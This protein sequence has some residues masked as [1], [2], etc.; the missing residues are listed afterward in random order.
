[1]LR[2]SII[3]I[4]ARAVPSVFGFVTG[5]A[6]T[7]LLTP[8]QYG[9]YGLGLATVT[10]LAGV[11][12]DWHALSFMR[13]F[14]AN[15]ANPTFMPTVTQSFLMLCALSGAL[16]ATVDASGWLSQDY[17]GL[18]WVSLPGCWAFAW[19]ELVSRVEVARF[20]PLR[21]FRMNLMRN[22]LI[23]A[24]SVLAAWLLRAPLWV[25]A[26]NYL[27]MMLTALAFH[28]SGIRLAPKMFDGGLARRLIAFGWAMAI[29]RAA[30]GVSFALDRMLLETLADRAA[31]GYYT[32]AYS[33]AQTTILMIG[34][35]IGSA[36]YSL[37]VRAVDGG[38]RAAIHAQLSRNCALLFGLL[39][40]AT[41]GV[42]MVAP[43]I[44]R[45][46]V[47]AAFEG[48]VASL[49]AWLAIGALFYGFRANYIDHAFQLGHSTNRLALVVAAAVV[50]NLL[51]DILLI[52]RFG[53]VGCAMAS[54][55]ASAVG[56]VLGII[57]SRG[58]MTMPIPA[59]DMMKTGIASLAMVLFLW[60]FHGETSPVILAVQVIGGVAIY[61]ALMVAMDALGLRG[62][63]R[64]RWSRAA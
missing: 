40:P 42:A 61:G 6:L 12:F 46:C 17:R 62:K 32:V 28:P 57:L 2:D 25:L 30:G 55:V 10:L 48:P 24:L 36:T 50:V 53:Y 33:L 7:W 59:R 38:D 60:P 26:A 54:L 23:L 3:Y 21:Y 39:L 34:S 19:F 63:L 15:A 16:A 47:S 4:L 44:A 1:M 29:V 43:G 20:R 64:A 56:L 18:L 31:V 49:I 9:T 13:F 37:A 52:P 35:G 8:T 5:M 14:Q 45:L 22:A 41:I 58:A 11:F 27:A 51:L